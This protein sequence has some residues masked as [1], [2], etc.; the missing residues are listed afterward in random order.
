MNI[1]LEAVATFPTLMSF[2]DFYKEL[3][4][5]QEAE[6]SGVGGYQKDWI[7]YNDKNIFCIAIVVDSS[8]KTG[9][10]GKLIEFVNMWDISPE[11][12]SEVTR[13]G[14]MTMIEAALNR[15]SYEYVI[16]DITFDKDAVDTKYWH[17]LIGNKESEFWG[18]KTLNATVDVKEF[19]DVM[20]KLVPKSAV[21][22]T[23][24]K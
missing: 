21:N 24:V 17:D 8:D 9:K 3:H 4:T 23:N 14:Y 18:K 22:Y 19:E 10:T 15:S 5:V 1:Q 2:K 13:L 6:S 11:K 16:A 7:I 20:A 12:M